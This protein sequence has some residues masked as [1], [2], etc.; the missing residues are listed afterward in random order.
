MIL[1]I[2]KSMPFQMRS[3]KP[4]D[5]PAKA[6]PR[7]AAKAQAGHPHAAAALGAPAAG[8]WPRRH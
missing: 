1:A 8:G 7:V 4:I 5:N 2:A 3:T 6:E